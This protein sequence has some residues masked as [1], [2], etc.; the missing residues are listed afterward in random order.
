MAEPIK[1]YAKHNPV[2]I[3]AIPA[4]REDETDENRHGIAETAEI[5]GVL[6]KSQNSENPNAEA[7]QPARGEYL[8]SETFR[9]RVVIDDGDCPPFV[10]DY[11]TSFTE[12]TEADYT[13][14]TLT[15]TERQSIANWVRSLG[16]SEA[17]IQEETAAVITQCADPEAKAFFLNY[18]K[19]VPADDRYYCRACQNF[20]TKTRYCS[21]KESRQID[22]IP[23]HCEFSTMPRPKSRYDDVMDGLTVVANLNSDHELIA[24]AKR[25]GLLVYIGRANQRH[26]YTG[27]IWANEPLKDDSDKT[28]H[29]SCDAYEDRLM[30]NKPLLRRISGL[31]GKVLAC[32][33][34]P[35]RCHCDTLERLANDFKPLE[36]V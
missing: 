13:E 4:I 32:Y 3:P 30:A 7:L 1:F 14:T 9:H 8:P 5:A 12:V 15:D 27:S 28:R 21:I 16:G 34:Y 33:C 23:R 2:A 18:A 17:E 36:C 11:R 10:A 35:M 24:W 22:D 31:K 29:E 25:N 20:N 19:E 6:S 26:G